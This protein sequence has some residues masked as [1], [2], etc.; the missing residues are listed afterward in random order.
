MVRPR[1]LWQGPVARRHYSRA[2][3]AALDELAAAGSAGRWAQLL[4][5]LDRRGS[6]SPNGWQ[7]EGGNWSTPLHYAAEHGAPGE[8]VA[9]LLLRGAWRAMP[10][11]N[12]D[13][14]FDVALRGNQDHLLDL[15]G[16]PPAYRCAP[17]AARALDRHL[18]EVIDKRLGARIE[19]RY[20]SVRILEELPDGV[21][22]W[23]PVPGVSGGFRIALAAER[24][25]VVS[26]SRMVDGSGQRHAVTTSG[27]ELVAERFV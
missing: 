11:A 9:E 2:A 3:L 20:P 26:W 21:E 8:V 18:R 13:T 7:P 15:L 27:Y 19:V 5:L 4:E 23:F 1:A 12:G 24:I 6:A 16:A 22:L 17:D 14:A 25:E 10:D